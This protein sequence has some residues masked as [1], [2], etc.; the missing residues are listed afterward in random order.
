MLM[1]RVWEKYYYRITHVVILFKLKND[2]SDK[3]NIILLEI[4]HYFV[5]RIS[6]GQNKTY[7]ITMVNTISH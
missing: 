5:M 3:K 4:S 6:L 7:G 2:K 1:C